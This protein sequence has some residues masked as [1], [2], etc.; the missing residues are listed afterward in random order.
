MA[1]LAA[2]DL[3]HH[4]TERR[5]PNGI[6]TARHT[7]R[8]RRIMTVPRSRCLNKTNQLLV[9]LRDDCGLQSQPR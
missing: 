4:K 9:A 3:W 8:S 2:P 7:V 5:E 1:N 6:H